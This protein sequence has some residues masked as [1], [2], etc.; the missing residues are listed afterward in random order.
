[1]C[2][3]QLYSQ[4]R[5]AR[6][7]LILLF[8]L[9]SCYTDFMQADE[10]QNYWKDDQKS[11]KIEG[12]YEPSSADGGDELANEPKN[13]AEA[14]EKAPEVK[15]FKHV[16]P[17]H[18]QAKEYIDEERGGLWFA[19]FVLV[20]LGLIMLDIFLIKSYTFSALVVVM[21]VALVVYVRRP[22][23][24][25]SYTLSADQG[26]YVGERLYHFADFK[27][28]SVIKDRDNHFIMLIPVKRFQPGVSVYFPEEVGES[29]VDIFGSRLPMENMKL[30][31]LDVIVRKLRL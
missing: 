8:L 4:Y 1:M 24:E 21:A 17:V 2:L 16:E 30:D 11:D 20:V 22:A 3:C 7:W 23:V 31:V 13:T 12:I 25:I 18:W 29:I 14:S 10:K 5:H 6:F 26:L 15:E 27:S 9:P 19:G 28:F